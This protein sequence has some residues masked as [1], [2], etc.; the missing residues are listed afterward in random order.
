MFHRKEKLRKELDENLIRVL[1]DCKNQWLN[2]KRIIEGSIEP[3]EEVLSQL[4]LAEAKY[5]FLLKEARYKNSVFPAK[6]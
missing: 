2:Q 4:R 5:L 3:S 1:T 6:K